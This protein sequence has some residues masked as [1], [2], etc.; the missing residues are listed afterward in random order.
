M[1]DAGPSASGQSGD[2]VPD[3]AVLFP[4]P[5]LQRVREGRGLTRAEVA[6]L[7]QDLLVGGGVTAKQI[8]FME[9]TGRLPDVEHCVPVLD[10]LY[11]LDGWLGVETFYGAS[12][13]R[14]A[15]RWARTRGLP[16]SVAVHQIRFPDFVVGPVW[17]QA[18]GQSGQGPGL[19]DMVWGRGFGPSVS[20]Q[21][22]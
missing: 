8:E 14:A 11:R 18:V 9:R 13:A 20:R 12:G 22:S 6:R 17:V 4:G 10:Y 16:K 15:S 7:S 21:E 2:L 3:R 19:V 1:L 5:G